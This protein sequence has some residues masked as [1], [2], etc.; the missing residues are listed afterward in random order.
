MD[1]VVLV[2][3]GLRGGCRFHSGGWRK[4]DP[5]SVCGDFEGCMHEAVEDGWA[6]EGQ[7]CICASRYCRHRVVPQ[8]HHSRLLCISF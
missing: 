5:L 2:H 3:F 6:D 1:L 4:V 8:M 7:P